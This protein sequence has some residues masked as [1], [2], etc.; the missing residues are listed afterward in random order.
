MDTSFLLIALVLVSLVGYMAYAK[1]QR[2]QRTFSSLYRPADERL[3][4]EQ[5]ELDE[6]GSIA[7]EGDSDFTTQPF[8]MTAGDYKL[9][10]WFPESALV[11]VELYSEDGSDKEVIAI[12]SGEG[13]VGFSVDSSGRYFCK[14][15]PA[16]D[17]R[18]E[19]EI[20]RLKRP[21]LS[22]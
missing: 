10:Y 18:W 13:E 2:D 22:G 6:K 7:F 15:E 4:S 1:S 12:K 11:Q 9:M 20:R 17:D 14:I 19:I 21:A 8:S 5:T 16:K 3:L